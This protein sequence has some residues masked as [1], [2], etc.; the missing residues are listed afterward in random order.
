MTKSRTTVQKFFQTTTGRVL[1]NIGIVMIVFMSASIGMNVFAENQTSHDSAMN[2]V[3]QYLWNMTHYQEIQQLGKEVD[4]AQG[5]MYM[6]KRMQGKPS[7]W[8]TQTKEDYDVMYAT[9]QE[10]INHYNDLIARYE[11]GDFQPKAFAKDYMPY[12]TR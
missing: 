1:Y 6:F 10:R 2:P 7:T 11:G 3:T 5:R 8:G 9:Q 4:Y 12:A